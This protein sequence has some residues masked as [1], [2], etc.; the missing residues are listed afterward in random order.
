MEEAVE[1]INDTL[2]ELHFKIDQLLPKAK[3]ERNVQPF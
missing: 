3:K 1:P 2:E